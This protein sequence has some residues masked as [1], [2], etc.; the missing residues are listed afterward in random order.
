MQNLAPIKGFA[1][2]G[3]ALLV[4]VGGFFWTPQQKIQREACL[5]DFTDFPDF[6][7]VASFKGHDHQQIGI[8]VPPCFTPCQRDGR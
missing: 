7:D 1:Q 8:G 2:E 6:A 3:V 5:A 4:A